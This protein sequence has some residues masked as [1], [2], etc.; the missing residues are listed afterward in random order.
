MIE[1]CVNEILSHS[2]GRVKYVIVKGSR[3]GETG[4]VVYEEWGVFV[5]Q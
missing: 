3:V 5:W 4:P 2:I 1:V